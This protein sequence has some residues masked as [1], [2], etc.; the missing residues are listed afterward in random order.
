MNRA[1]IKL[2]EI[3]AEKL[4]KVNKMIQYLNDQL[5]RIRV[6]K[7]LPNRNVGDKPY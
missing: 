3:T 7:M 2:T 4:V 5:K 6:H 1:I